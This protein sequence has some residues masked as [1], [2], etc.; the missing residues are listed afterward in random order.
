MFGNSPGWECGPEA[1]PS[2]RTFTLKKAE[3][4]LFNHAANDLFW[5]IYTLWDMAKVSI[6]LGRSHSV[7][8]WLKI[9]KLPQ[10]H[11]GTLTLLLICASW[12]ISR[13]LWFVHFRHVIP[14]LL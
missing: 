5:D 1:P 14:H 4:A 3:I 11:Y 9:A 12:M 10:M 8:I 13:Q 6:F 2:T 7:R